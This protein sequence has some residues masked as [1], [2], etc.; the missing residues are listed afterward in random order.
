MNDGLGAEQCIRLIRG[1]IHIPGRSREGEP[2][3]VIHLGRDHH[4]HS[5]AFPVVHASTFRC[6]NELSIAKGD[7]NLVGSN[8][9][10][11]MLW[12]VNQ[13]GLTI[14]PPLYPQ[15]LGMSYKVT[16]PFG[17]AVPLTPRH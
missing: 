7:G 8:R 2:L 5:C 1:V 17:Y 13:G 14:S 16:I 12:S 6:N 9:L 11:D 3:V 15:L 10:G 4:L